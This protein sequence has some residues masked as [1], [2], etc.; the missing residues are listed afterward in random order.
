[1]L[2]NSICYKTK[3]KQNKLGHNRKAQNVM[4]LKNSICEEKNSKFRSLKNLKTERMAK[5]NNFFFDKT[6]IIS[7]FKEL[8]TDETQKLNLS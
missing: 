1:M 5:L 3:Q 2:K 7:Q 8:G 6:Q 4:K